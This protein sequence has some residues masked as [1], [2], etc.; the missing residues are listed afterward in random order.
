MSRV[1]I[2]NLTQ[3]IASN[4]SDLLLSPQYLFLA[5]VD[6]CKGC[7]QASSPLQDLTPLFPKLIPLHRGGASGFSFPGSTWE[8]VETRPPN[9][10]WVNAYGC[11]WQSIWKTNC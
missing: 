2:L 9:R 1:K 4:S 3:G 8:R 6:L 7:F 5:W 11:D 10:R